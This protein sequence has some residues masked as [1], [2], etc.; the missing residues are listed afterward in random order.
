MSKQITFAAAVKAG[1]KVVDR[2]AAG[3]WKLGEI[4][5]QCKPE[6]GNDTI[7][8]LA[9]EIDP[10]G[11]LSKG[12][13]QNYRTAVR[14]YAADQR[15]TGNSITVYG[16]FASQ[17]DAMELLTSRVWSVTDARELVKSRK[18]AGNGP[19]E[20]DGNGP[21]EPAELSDADK[22][23]KLV[24]EITRLEGALQIARAALVKF[25]A[26]HKPADKPEPPA[27][28][29]DQSREVLPECLVCSKRHYAGSA[30]AIRHA[31]AAAA[32]AKVA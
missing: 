23:S 32:A 9:A 13:L 3:A 17:K 5:D 19:A 7:A 15:N 18:P 12:T 22:R 8:R 10:S 31:E 26:D 25:D 1:Q 14:K 30:V 16:I 2:Q 11:Q 28:V 6:Y 27:I 20:G 24:A 21:A 29:A 4:A